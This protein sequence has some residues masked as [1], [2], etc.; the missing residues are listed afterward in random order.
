VS[1]LNKNK[2]KF[3]RLRDD[4]KLVLDVDDPICEGLVGA[5]LSARSY[6]IHRDT[7]L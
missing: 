7:G 3:N 1:T 5:S 2:N 6:K 4:E